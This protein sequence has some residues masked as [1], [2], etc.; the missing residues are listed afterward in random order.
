M[1][2]KKETIG[3]KLLPISIKKYS[4]FSAKKTPTETLESEITRHGR[5]VKKEEAEERVQA[6]K[7]PP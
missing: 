5:K 3:K 6:A 1:R 7:C 2:Q 4:T